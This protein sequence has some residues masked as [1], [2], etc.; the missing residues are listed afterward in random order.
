MNVFF[1]IG[2]YIIV[3]NLLFYF[4]FN[5]WYQISVYFYSSHV[6]LDQIIFEL[7]YGQSDIIYINLSYME[8]EYY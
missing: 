2:Y 3:C 6:Y 7:V 5:L 1:I 8:K 4:L